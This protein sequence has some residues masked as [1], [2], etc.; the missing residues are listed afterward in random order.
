[1]TGVS[2][3][4][5]TSST[6]IAGVA[7]SGE[8]QQHATRLIG[9]VDRVQHELLAPNSPARRRR[10]TPGR[11]RGGPRRT[12]PALGVDPR[13]RESGLAGA[14]VGHLLEREFRHAVLHH[15]AEVRR[16][17]ARR[18]QPG[19]SRSG[20][21]SRARGSPSRCRHPGCAL[22]GHCARSRRCSRW[23]R[24]RRGGGCRRCSAA[25]LPPPP[26]HGPARRPSI[27]FGVTGT[28]LSQRSDPLGEQ[29]QSQHL[30]IEVRFLHTTVANGFDQLRPGGCR[31]GHREVLRGGDGAEAAHGGPVRDDDAVEAPLRVQRVFEQVGSRS[32]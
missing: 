25:R 6:K 18:G 13:R 22:R 20:A 15:R 1:M 23:R 14:G 10:R 4:T 27:S 16:R 17:P 2:S 12:A 5:S 7:R 9:G 28:R 26:P 11:S 29:Q 32:S 24:R 19:G 8:A 31:A 30:S 21:R 3:T